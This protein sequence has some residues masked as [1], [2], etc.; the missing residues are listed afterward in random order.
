MY[1]STL[2]VVVL[3]LI[4]A[5]SGSVVA[6]RKQLPAANAVLLWFMPIW[7]YFA[8]ECMNRGGC[9]WI[10]WVEVARQLLTVIVYIAAAAYGP[11]VVSKY[12]SSYDAE[13]DI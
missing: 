10:V 13:Y 7:L 6:F 1:L 9:A 3:S 2:V 5:I 11:Q 4:S 12:S 8:G